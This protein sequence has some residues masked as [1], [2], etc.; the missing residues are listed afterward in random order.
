MAP[1][2]TAERGHF[3]LEPASTRTSH[4]VQDQRR[5]TAL[6]S[7]PLHRRAAGSVRPARADADPRRGRT[8]TDAPAG[9]GLDA[10]IHGCRPGAAGPVR[11]LERGPAPT[12]ATEQGDGGGRA[13]PEARVVRG[14]RGAAEGGG[15]AEGWV[16]SLPPGRPPGRPHPACAVHDPRG[17]RYLAGSPPF[18]A[19]A[20]S[21]VR[22]RVDP[23]RHTRPLLDR[24]ESVMRASGSGGQPRSRVVVM[25]LTRVRGCWRPEPASPRSAGGGAPG[26][27][28]R[29]GRRT[30]RWVARS[31]RRWLSRTRRARTWPTRSRPRWG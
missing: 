23:L 10:E 22:L 4:H 6:V 18:W 26:G 24:P 29:V 27:P 19:G 5:G 1:P 13:Q 20:S 12:L 7:R 16:C 11:P 3:T 8:R 25:L 31:R 21:G 15:P 14:V 17:T 9:D 2:G 28:R 30:R